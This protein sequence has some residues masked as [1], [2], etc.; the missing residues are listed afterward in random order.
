[1]TNTNALTSEQESAIVKMLN[2]TWNTINCDL[3]ERMTT[4]GAIEVLLDADYA[5]IYGGDGVAYDL[6]MALPAERQEAIAR[7][8]FG[9]GKWV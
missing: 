6:L 8:L 2:K 4:D 7:R 5:L 3:P 1:M 9:G